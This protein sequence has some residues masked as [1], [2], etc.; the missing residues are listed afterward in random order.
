MMAGIRSEY[1]K[2]RK[3][4][5]QTGDLIIA[6]DDIYA[7]FSSPPVISKDSPLFCVE[8]TTPNVRV[9]VIDSRTEKKFW[10]SSGLVYDAQPDGSWIVR[11]KFSDGLMECWPYRG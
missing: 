7:G 6:S 3:S 2:L 5:P 9:L 8:S 4:W 11:G 1:G 10:L